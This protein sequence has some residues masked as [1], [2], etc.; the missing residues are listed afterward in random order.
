MP[1][2]AD[3]CVVMWRR[4][5]IQN[6]YEEM[7]MTDNQIQQRAVDVNVNKWQRMMMMTADNNDEI[8]NTTDVS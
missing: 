3:L 7:Q 8:K 2:S 6:V 4:L 5:P 1:I